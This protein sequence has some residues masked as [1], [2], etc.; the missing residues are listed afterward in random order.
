MHPVTRSWLGAVGIALALAASLGRAQS[1]AVQP[2]SGAQET[3]SKPAPLC[4]VDAIDVTLC[5]S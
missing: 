2:H 3:P 5:F 1:T 4:S